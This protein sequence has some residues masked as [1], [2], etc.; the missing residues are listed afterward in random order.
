[1]VATIHPVL[2]IGI[3]HSRLRTY[4]YR[5]ILHIIRRYS[6]VTILTG[7]CV[8]TALTVFIDT[9]VLF[10]SIKETVLSQ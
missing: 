10:F 2:A 7:W 6:I 4:R 9:L 1:M 3:C 5:V 8:Y